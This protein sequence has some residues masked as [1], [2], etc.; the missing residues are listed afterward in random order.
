MCRQLAIYPHYATYFYTIPQN[1]TFLPLN[2]FKPPAPG[3]AVLALVTIHAALIRLR[4]KRQ[5]QSITGIQ[6]FLYHQH[7]TL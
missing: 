3:R 7:I 6:A 5:T 2:I 1:F 4:A